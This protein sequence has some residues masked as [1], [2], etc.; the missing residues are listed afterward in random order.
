M[1]FLFDLGGVFFDWDP[2]YFFRNIFKNSEEMQYFLENICNHEWNIKQDAGR[3]IKD[4]EYELINKYPEHQK[5]IKMYYSNHRKMI[6][7]TYKNSI[8]ILNELNNSSFECYV[9]SNWSSETFRGMIQDYPFLKK[10]DGMVI[11]GD[12]KL[13][14]PDPNIYFF[15]IKKFKLIP[16]ETVFIDD[17]LDNINAAKVIGFKTIHLKDPSIIK[18]LIKKYI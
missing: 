18:E 8:D 16:N 3:L 5:L 4:A 15:A 1:K 11:S 13:V 12:V 6:R 14:K 17:K 9:L 10:F 7:G 2:K